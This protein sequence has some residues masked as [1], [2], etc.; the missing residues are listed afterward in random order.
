MSANI[1]DLAAV[2]EQREEVWQDDLL[3]WERD[4]TYLMPQ[5]VED[6]EP[7]QF[8]VIE[9]EEMM[10][11]REWEVV[12]DWLEAGKSVAVWQRHVMWA[13]QYADKRFVSFV[14]EVPEHLSSLGTEESDRSRLIGF[15]RP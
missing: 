6:T 3:P 4:E 1:V 9:L 8:T 5:V 13:W 2:R 10:G 12:N 7:T 11:P 14:G 15:A